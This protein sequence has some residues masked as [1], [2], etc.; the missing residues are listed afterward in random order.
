MITNDTKADDEAILA[1]GAECFLNLLI[2]DGL[3]LLI[4]L[5]THR[6]LY[7]LIWSASFLLVR[8]NLGGLHA[9]SHFGC[10]ISG[11]IIGASSMFISPL[12]AAHTNVA[13]ICA[14]L[15]AIIAVLIAP[16]P[17]KNKMHVQK[18]R[19]KIK[20]I[21]AATIFIEL[22]AI[23]AFYFVNEMISAYIISGLVIATIFA[24]AGM[25]FNPR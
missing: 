13:A 16:V 15:S 17:H 23:F 11:T 19:K 3:L 4:G 24:V 2:S 1:Y 5:F 12:W 22:I 21:V 14:L 20:L 25:I 10:I 7:L 6:V 18:R 9:P 8:V